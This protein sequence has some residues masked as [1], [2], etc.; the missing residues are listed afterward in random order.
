MLAAGDARHGRALENR[1]GKGKA[2]R[3]PLGPS[4][5]HLEAQRPYV[6]KA[7]LNRRTHCGRYCLASFPRVS[8]HSLCTA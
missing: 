5:K 8:K 6:D 4:F 3:H 7:R 2:L 1:E